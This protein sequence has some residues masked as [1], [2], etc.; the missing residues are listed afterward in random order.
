M[1]NP[2]ALILGG[3]GF[4]FILLMKLIFKIVFLEG[5]KYEESIDS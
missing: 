3:I 5:D 2:I 4:K 1:D